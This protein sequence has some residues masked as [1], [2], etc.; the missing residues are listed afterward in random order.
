MIH[1]IYRSCK[2]DRFAPVQALCVT[3]WTW[4]CWFSACNAQV[5]NA[6]AIQ[7]IDTSFENAS[8][9]WYESLE[10]GTTAVHLMYDHERDSTNRAAGHIHIRLQAAAGARVKLE[11]RNLDNI[12][13]G[14]PGSVAKEMHRLVI[15]PDGKNWQSVATEVLENRVRLEVHMP[16]D[17]LYVARVEP[18]RISD[19][20]RFLDRVK[21]HSLVQLTSLGKTL[22]GRELDM[23]RIGDPQAIH[24]VFVRARAHPWEA[25]GNWIVEG[26]V[27]G[28]LS[29]DDDSKRLLQHTCFWILPMANKDGVARGRTRFNLLGKDLNRDWLAPAEQATAPENYALE[30]WL[31][32]RLNAGKR[33]DFALEVH[34]D[35]NGSLHH[36]HPPEAD[37]A[38]YTTR[39]ETFERLLR[40]HTWFSVGSS[41]SAV[42]V[43]TLPNGWQKRFGI[44]GAVHEFNC[45]WIERL[46]VG[47]LKEH[48][49]DYGRGLINVFDRFLQ[50]S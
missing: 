38:R 41:Q 32:A 24:Q 4:I 3:I 44:D 9:V 28:L 14:R 1:P 6:N 34:N 29:G 11:F 49:Q 2:R 33:F 43:G 23:L 35:G 15:S 10:D 50:S 18:Y 22:E 20:N 45:Q 26:L 30:K 19:L 48:W 12:Y 17:Q 13:N 16:S 37:K 27:N 25:G 21:S 8:P 39:M 42:G 40:E 31:E 7:F 47:P 36:T 5:P 46:Q